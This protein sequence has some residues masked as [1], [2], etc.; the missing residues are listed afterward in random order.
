MISGDNFQFGENK[1][2]DSY[3]FSKYIHGW[4]AT[5]KRTWDL[6]D[7]N[8]SD[9]DQNS[10]D[11]IVSEDFLDDEREIVFWKNTLNRM[12]AGATDAWDYQ[13]CYY[14]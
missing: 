11:R 4:G 9:Y 12:Y 3:Y 10:V 6:F 13:F 14:L 5:W 2:E 1:T 8:M 7:I